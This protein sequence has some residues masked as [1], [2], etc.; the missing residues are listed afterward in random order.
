[1]LY[2]A[3]VQHIDANRPHALVEGDSHTGQL[4]YCYTD[5]GQNVVTPNA[6]WNQPTEWRTGYME[7]MA[8]KADSEAERIGKAAPLD[9]T[10]EAAAALQEAWRGYA[11]RIRSEIARL[12]A[13]HDPERPILAGLMQVHFGPHPMAR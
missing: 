4:T 5:T 2:S 3:F 9:M 13:A 10:P 7:W 6:W 1:M 12:M 11:G 8:Q